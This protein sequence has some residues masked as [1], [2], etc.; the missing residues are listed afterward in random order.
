MALHWHPVG[1]ESAETYWMR[2]ALV[3]LAVLVPLV[4]LLSLL[5]GGG[6]DALVEAD[7]TASPSP[8]PSAASSPD[9]NASPDPSA[10]PGTSASPGASASPTASPT[11]A[12]AA[13]TDAVLR[14]E[15]A[16]TEATYA[17][18]ASPRL[19]LTVTNTGT[20]PCSRDLGQA[21]VELQV[22]SGADRI[23]S[24]DDC[25]PGGD[26]DV[27]TLAPGKA[28]VSTVTWSGTR[29]RPGCEGDEERAT[30]GTYRVNGR[31]GEL[32]ESGESFVLR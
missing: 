15:A 17:V 23:W 21:A 11:A 14:V 18:G 3:A 2:R 29:S 28:E 1:P 5:T 31:V 22:V 30:A 26:A 8:E 16:A 24:S 9:P 27:V 19:Q 20:T 6:D 32:R 13:C 12:A 25:A 7:A 10:S 4:L